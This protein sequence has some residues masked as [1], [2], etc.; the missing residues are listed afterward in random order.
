MDIRITRAILS[1]PGSHEDPRASEHMAEESLAIKSTR[2]RQLR[3]KDSAL[4]RFSLPQTSFPTMRRVLHSLLS[5]LVNAVRE[6]EVPQQR[7]HSKRN[8]RL[9]S[10]VLRFPHAVMNGPSTTNVPL[11]RSTLSHH[12]HPRTLQASSSGTISYIRQ[13][14]QHTTNRLHFELNKL[15]VMKTT[16]A[17]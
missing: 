13:G 17:R 6:S 10:L 4:I 3:A 12:C 7:S 14:I 9:L 8:L 11:L 15:T 5:R 1:E 2:S 16:R